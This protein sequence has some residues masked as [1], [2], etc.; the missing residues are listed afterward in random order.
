MLTGSPKLA[1]STEMQLEVPSLP[2]NRSTWRHFCAAFRKRDVMLVLSIFSDANDDFVKDMSS[3]LYHIEDVCQGN[4]LNKTV[5]KCSAFTMNERPRLLRHSE[6]H[7]QIPKK[8]VAFAFHKAPHFQ[9]LANRHQR[10][11][12]LSL[13]YAGKWNWRKSVIDFDKDP[14]KNNWPK[15]LGQLCC[16][17]RNLQ[18]VSLWNAEENKTATSLTNTVDFKPADKTSRQVV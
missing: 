16:N 1:S 10:V 9:N 12:Q 18:N 8:G 4:L 2:K 3:L 17:Y 5:K 11:D 15:V 6:I 13:K 14:G 7:S